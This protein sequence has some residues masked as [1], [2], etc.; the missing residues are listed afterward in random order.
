M[1]ED[2]RADGADPFGDDQYFTSFDLDDYFR[3]TRKTDHATNAALHATLKAVADR[4]DSTIANVNLM[5]S[6][7]PHGAERR[8]KG[9]PRYEVVVDIENA[10][11]GEASIGD[12]IIADLIARGDVAVTDVHA[13]ARYNEVTVHEG[14]VDVVEAVEATCEQAVDRLTVHL[15]PIETRVEPVEVPY[16][17]VPDDFAELDDVERVAA[18]ILAKVVDTY[19]SNTVR[20]F[21]T[22]RSLAATVYTL[23]PDRYADD[24]EEP[25]AAP[26][27]AFES[28][29]DRAGVEP[30]YVE[31]R[32]HDVDDRAAHIRVTVDGDEYTDV[33]RECERFPNLPDDLNVYV[34]Q[35]DAFDVDDGSIEEDDGGYAKEKTALDARIAA[36]QEGAYEPECPE[37]GKSLRL[38]GTEA[39]FRCKKCETTA[40]AAEIEGWS[41]FEDAVADREADA[42]DRRPN[43][44]LTGADGHA[45]RDVE[46]DGGGRYWPMPARFDTHVEECP[47]CGADTTQDPKT[48]ISLK[49]RV[50][51]TVVDGHVALVAEAK[52]PCG[53]HE[54]VTIG[55]NDATISRI[56]ATG[57]SE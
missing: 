2:T 52:C 6:H 57:A 17:A 53:Y 45:D 42:V 44:T 23:A 7:A 28:L 26:H 19:G 40:D 41:E 56:K 35:I 25:D 22:A 21:E 30:Q 13:A 39:V 54:S 31:E 55:G 50:R 33:V 15:N 51:V 9:E 29:C 43:A 4:D 5:A 49:T 47:E 12:T 37:C 8:A 11:M 27:A 46:T 48:D 18:R 38:F 20:A 16:S 1:G 10:G 34:S 36:I 24:V 14:D 32:D 3:K